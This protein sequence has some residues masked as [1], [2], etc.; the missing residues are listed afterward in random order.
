MKLEGKSKNAV[1]GAMLGVAAIA[2]AFWI[3]A[4]SPKREEAK[5][6][7]VQVEQLE[8]SLAQ[9]EA[10]VDAGEE[11]RES[12]PVD[13]S[14]LV[15]LGKAVPGDD[16]TAS[17]LVQVNRIADKAEVRFQT[18]ELS[19]GSGGDGEAPTPASATG[20]PVSATEAAA[21]LLPLGAGIG[22][23]GLAVMP[24]TLTFQGNFFEIADFIEGLDS[25]VKTTNE[26]AVVDGRLITVDGFSL[27]EN[28]ERRFP[29]LQA[30]FSVT[31][32]LTPPG[33]GITAGASPGGFEAA[34]ATPAAT[35]TG[36]AP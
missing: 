15:V 27:T 2:A 36:G 7:G 29:E 12:F 24:Y 23:A 25:L 18:L 20:E 14:K 16:D 26:E 31:T 35:T 5:E 6:L 21:S 10:E 28:P 1:I 33:Q 3:L 13:Y 34:T 22:P 8:S 30:S 11:A 32:Y 17:L 4:L 19:P 9:H